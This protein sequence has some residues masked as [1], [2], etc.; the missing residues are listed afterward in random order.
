MSIKNVTRRR[1]I[2]YSLKS[3]LLGTLGLAGG[4]A[5]VATMPTKEQGNNLADN[6]EKKVKEESREGSRA[7]VLALTPAMLALSAY[8]GCMAKRVFCKPQMNTG[9]EA[10]NK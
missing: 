3:F 10:K 4:A 2:E 1:F 8:N 5:A 6:G 7:I 9:R